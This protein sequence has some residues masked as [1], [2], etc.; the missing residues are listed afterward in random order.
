MRYLSWLFKIILFVLLLG[1]AIKNTETTVIHYFLGYE[2]QAPLVLILLIFFCAG[3]AIGIMASF[4]YIFRQKRKMRLL[5]RE[6]RLK[7]EE[8]R[9]ATQ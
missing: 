5:E 1:F 2:W 3:A 7:D 9:Q 4:G 8:S 6:L